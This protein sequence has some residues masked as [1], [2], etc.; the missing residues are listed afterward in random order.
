M[1]VQTSTPRGL[2]PAA[3]GGDGHRRRVV[4]TDAHGNRDFCRDGENCLIAEPDPSRSAALG[5]GARRRRAARRLVEAACETAAE[6]AW[7][8]RID[9]LERFFELGARLQLLGDPRRLAVE[10]PEAEHQQ[11]TTIARGISRYS[12]R[13]SRPTRLGALGS[14]TECRTCSRIGGER[15]EPDHQVLERR[16]GTISITYRIGE[17]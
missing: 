16:V 10:D 15:V 5:P 7:E 8:R 2:L 12:A 17:A 3:A 6:Y 11:P 13:R 4:C 9:R 1:F 14:I